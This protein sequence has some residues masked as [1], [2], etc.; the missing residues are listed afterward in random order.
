MHLY[1]HT[2]IQHTSIHFHPPSIPYHLSIYT[3][4]WV[5]I[6]SQLEK[7]MVAIKNKRLDGELIHSQRT[8]VQMH[9]Y[10]SL[11]SRKSTLKLQEMTV[12]ISTISTYKPSIH[13]TQPFNRIQNLLYQSLGWKRL[14]GNITMYLKKIIQNNVSYYNNHMKKIRSQGL[15]QNTNS[16]A[17]RNNGYRHLGTSGKMDAEL[18]TIHASWGTRLVVRAYRRRP[19]STFEQDPQSSFHVLILYTAK[20]IHL[21]VIKLQSSRSR[22][23]N[24]ILNVEE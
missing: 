21:H 5:T 3:V 19:C 12:K 23:Q 10:K 6:F 8:Q 17:E 9:T 18:V 13:K 24:Q 15:A 1:I 2:Y 11:R 14:T 7:W 20:K 4:H 22:L 16:G